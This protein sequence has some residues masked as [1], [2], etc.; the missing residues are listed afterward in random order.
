MTHH[1]NP[2]PTPSAPP[3]PSTPPTPSAL[4]TPSGPATP[5]AAPTVPQ[6]TRLGNFWY[7]NRGFLI[8]S[9]LGSFAA[10]FLGLIVDSATIIS[11][12]SNTHE[13]YEGW[14]MLKV[15]GIGLA[16]YINAE[17]RSGLRRYLP[18]NDRLS[19]QSTSTA[20]VYTSLIPIASDGN[21]PNI[22][23]NPDFSV[24]ENTDAEVDFSDEALFRKRNTQTIQAFL[25]D[26]KQKD[27]PVCLKVYGQRDNNR[28]LY[29]NIVRVKKPSLDSIESYQSLA[30]KG[31]MTSD[32][33]IKNPNV[34]K[35][36]ENA[37]GP[38]IK[39]REP[40]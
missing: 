8:A 7:Q 39:K 28:S 11:W 26:A 25:V 22:S 23:Q 18:W 36:I 27:I 1:H 37:C 38:A 32:N 13:N 40:T 14:V 12:L 6:R 17:Q 24:L 21:L 19:G 35:F 4:P 31:V 2:S 16:N 29:L 20:L 3:T 5:S 34:R 30:Q 9:M 33:V 10:P 15:N